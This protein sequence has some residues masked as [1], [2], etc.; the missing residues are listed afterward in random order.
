MPARSLR[1]SAV[2]DSASQVER[3]YGGIRSRIIDGS[4]RAGTQR[5]E[6]TAD[7]DPGAENYSFRS[8]V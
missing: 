7:P 4:Y 3:A 2:T 1:L 6:P 8:V 5:S